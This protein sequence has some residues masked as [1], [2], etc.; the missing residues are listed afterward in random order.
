MVW[1]FTFWNFWAL[2]FWKPKRSNGYS[3]QRGVHWTDSELFS[4]KFTTVRAR[5]ELFAV[6]TRWSDCAHVRC[7]Y[8]YFAK[9]VP[10]ASH[11][12]IWWCRMTC[13]LSGF[14]RLRIWLWGQFKSKVYATK[15]PCVANIQKCFR[16]WNCFNIKVHLS[17]VHRVMANFQKRLETCKAS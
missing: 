13:P 10:R 14:N 8:G 16:Q 5:N 15:H 11:L 9:T 4:S 12:T 1:Y 7:V 2:F 17:M 3:K 6:S